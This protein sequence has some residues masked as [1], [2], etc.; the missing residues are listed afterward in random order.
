MIQFYFGHQ[1]KNDW[2]H[3]AQSN[4]DGQGLEYFLWK[5]SAGEPVS[6]SQERSHLWADVNSSPG[7]SEEIIKL[8]EP[9]SSQCCTV[10]RGNYVGWNEST[11]TGKTFNDE[12]S[13]SLKEVLQEDSAISAEIVKVWLDTN[14]RNYVWLHFG[15]EVGLGTCITTCILLW[16]TK[17]MRHAAFPNSKEG[18]VALDLNMRSFVLWYFHMRKFKSYLF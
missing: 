17:D 12:D 11:H 6:S 1:Q 16:M 13:K 18:R 7:N 15:L 4:H 3:S 8:M 5:E 14:L 2:V 9:G 10:R